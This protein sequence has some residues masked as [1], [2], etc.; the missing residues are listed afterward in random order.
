MVPEPCDREASC[1][2][3]VVTQNIAMIV[4]MLGT[5]AFDDKPTLKTDEI[6]DINADRNLPTPFRRLQSAIPQETPQSPF[7]VRLLNTQR[8]SARF[9]RRRNGTMMNRHDTLML[10]SARTPLLPLQEKVSPKATDEG[11]A[12]QGAQLRRARAPTPRP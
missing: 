6:D 7:S 12:P 5:V 9:D 3:P 2:K 10:S 11:S 8:A 4:G 1:T